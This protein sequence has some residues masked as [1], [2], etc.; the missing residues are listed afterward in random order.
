MRATMLLI[1]VV[2]A[3]AIINA[4]SSSSCGAG[5]GARSYGVVN[6]VVVVVPCAALRMAVVAG[7]VG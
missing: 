3:C 2:R 4:S 7:G 6:L 5:S 1:C